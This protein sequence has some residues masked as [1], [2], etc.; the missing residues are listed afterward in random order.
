MWLINLLVKYVL[1]R[2]KN[3]ITPQHVLDDRDNDVFNE[4]VYLVGSVYTRSFH[5]IFLKIKV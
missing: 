4:I 1:D 3:V 5:V 2:S